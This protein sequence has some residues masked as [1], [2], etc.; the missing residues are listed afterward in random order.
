MVRGATSSGKDDE[1][2]ALVHG[3]TLGARDLL[4]FSGRG[5]LDRHL[6]LHRLENDARLPFEDVVT[7]F[8]FD[9]P[10]R[11]GDVRTHVGSHGQGEARAECFT[12]AFA[13]GLEAR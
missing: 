9:F 1:H 12:Q 5:R 13:S 8:D 10:N 2:V 6:H 3:L 4:D 7:L 11:P